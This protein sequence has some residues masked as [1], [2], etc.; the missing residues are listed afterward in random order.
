MAETYDDG[1]AVALRQTG[2]TFE[3]ADR[4]AL[5]DGALAR[6]R[7]RL[8]ARRTAAAAGGLLALAAV[9]FGGA[10]TGGLLGGGDGGNGQASV[11]SRDVAPTGPVTRKELFDDLARLLAPARL[12]D[13]SEGPD[14]SVRSTTVSAVYDDGK[15]KAAVIFSLDQVAA[16]SGRFTPTTCSDESERDEHCTTTKLPGGDQLMVYQGYEYPDRR[17]ETKRWRAVLFT[18]DGYQVEAAEWNAPAEKGAEISRTDPPL[19]P[20]ALRKLVTSDV[21]RDALKRLPRPVQGADSTVRPGSDGAGG[22]DGVDVGKTFLSL[23]PGGLKII[24]RGSQENAY[25]FAVVDDGKG[26]TRVEINVQPRMQDVEGELFTAGTVVLPDGTKLLTSRKPGEKG[27]A[28][29][30]RWIADTI[31]PDGLRVSVSETNGAFQQGPATRVKPA[32][33]LEQLNAIATSEKWLV[34]GRPA[35]PAEAGAGDTSPVG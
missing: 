17:V 19:G 31:R 21:W 22:T 13:V 9:G 7:R 15:G 6:G 25:A 8:A 30:V 33:S 27:G 35:D 18:A 28:G 3:P 1:L 34:H 12:T 26:P 11:A 5:V 23:L 20:A 4:S 2:G 29:M 10:W 14:G 16:V 24:D 32:L